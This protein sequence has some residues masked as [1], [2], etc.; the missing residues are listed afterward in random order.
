MLTTERRRLQCQR[1]AEL[2]REVLGDLFALHTGEPPRALR[3]YRESDAVMLLLR[4]DPRLAGSGV[5]AELEAR[6][7]AALM[8]MCEMVT[9]VVSQHSGAEIVAGNLS[10]CAT[11]GLAVFAMRV[12]G[13][14]QRSPCYRVRDGRGRGRREW[15]DLRLASRST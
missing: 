1:V 11:T 6:M 9:E 4:F 2:A 3:E 12:A 13:E 7:D 5:D 14:E 10:V 15:E 8:A